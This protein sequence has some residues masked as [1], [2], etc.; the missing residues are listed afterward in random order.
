MRRTSR[1][2]KE[3]DECGD[4]FIT[5]RVVC[6]MHDLVTRRTDCG[7][8]GTLSEG[9]DIGNGPHGGRRRFSFRT[10]KSTVAAAAAHY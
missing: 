3:G 10:R 1:Q 4:I 6:R 9:S 5:R 2:K 7:G 8:E